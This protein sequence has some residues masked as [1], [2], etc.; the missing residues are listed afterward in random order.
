M[1][2]RARQAH[3]PCLYADGKIGII[4][5]KTPA[6]VYLRQPSALIFGGLAQASYGNKRAS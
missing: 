6:T 5:Q 1:G 4:S 2:F 3:L